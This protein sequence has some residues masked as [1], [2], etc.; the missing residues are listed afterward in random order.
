MRWSTRSIGRHQVVHLIH[1]ERPIV[2]L[3]SV[4]DSRDLQSTQ[5]P[6]GG[7]FW[8]KLGKD[9]TCSHRVHRAGGRRTKGHRPRSAAEMSSSLPSDV[10]S[11][12][13]CLWS[14]CGTDTE[15]VTQKNMQKPVRRYEGNKV[16]GTKQAVRAFRRSSRSLL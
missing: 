1:N 13:I 14:P 2:M 5:P 9:I 7:R 16:S 12:Y 8:K 11:C 3:T 15:T 4:S 10:L 6:S